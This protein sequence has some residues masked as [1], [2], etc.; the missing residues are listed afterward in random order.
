MTTDLGTKEGNGAISK[1]KIHKIKLAPKF[2]LRRNC[3]PYKATMQTTMMYKSASKNV[4]C[5]GN[6][7][8]CR[9]LDDNV[10]VSPEFHMISSRTEIDK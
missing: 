9:D 1:A 10:K 5:H 3:K 2:L 8:N 6:Q 4:L 7:E